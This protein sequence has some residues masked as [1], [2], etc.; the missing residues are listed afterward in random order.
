[1]VQRDAES[2]LNLHSANLKPLEADPEDTRDGDVWYVKTAV[3]AG[4]IKFN[5]GGA[6]VTIDEAGTVAVQ[7]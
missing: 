1:M 6:I 7:A 4:K 3:D 2:R 5:I